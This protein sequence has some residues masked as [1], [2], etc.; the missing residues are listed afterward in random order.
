[1]LSRPEALE[2]AEQSFRSELRPDDP[3]LVID[4]QWIE[5]RHGYLVVPYNSPEFISSRDD[6]DRVLDCWPILVNLS[7]GEV[8][9][10][11]IAD[12]EF[13]DSLDQ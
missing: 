3:E 11:S 6:M 7:T 9:A 10:T 2:I 1:M 13:L 8:R 12:K 5:E 4:E